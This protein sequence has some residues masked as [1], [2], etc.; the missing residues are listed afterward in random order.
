MKQ[1]E[2]EVARENLRSTISMAQTDNSGRPTIYTILRR[3]SR[4]GMNRKISVIV[5]YAGTPMD[6][7]YWTATALGEKCRNVDGYNAVNV[8]GCGMDMGYHLADT[9]ARLADISDFRHQWL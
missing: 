5:I 1:S 4:S 8:D 2:K 3:V 7:S 9:V 6:I